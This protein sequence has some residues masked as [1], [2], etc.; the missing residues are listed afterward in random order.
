MAAKPKDGGPSRLE[1]YGTGVHYPP[2]PP[3]GEHL[4][5]L[6]RAMG[7]FMPGNMGPVGFSAQEL[8]AWS[9]GTR[10]PL[11]AWEFSTLLDMSRGYATELHGASDGARPP[12]WD[13]FAA[14]HSAAIGQRMRAALRS[15]AG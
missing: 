15:A 11:S 10:T 14:A 3:E 6:A 1:S 2:L 13:G 4:I 8:L 9:T 7:W 12:P 5:D